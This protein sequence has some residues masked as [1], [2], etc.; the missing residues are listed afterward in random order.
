MN[1]PETCR[2]AA[3]V[4]PGGELE[5]VEVP[6]PSE[7][8]PGAIL[9]KVSAAT[10]CATDAHMW[11]HGEQG[12]PYPSPIIAGHEMMGR[13]ARIGE[14][15]D[16]DSIGQDLKVG[17]RIVWSSGQCG[18]C[19]PCV[20][21]H[22]RMLCENVRLYMM[23]PSAQYP[24]LTGGFA[25]YCYVFPT[26][27]RLKVPDGISDALASGTSCAYRTVINAFDRLGRIDEGQSILIQGSGP[28]GL[29]A[30][31]LASVSGAAKVIVIGGPPARLELAREFGADCTI[32]IAEV[33]DPAERE[34]IVRAQTDGHG[35]DVV[36][37]LSGVP[38]AFNEGMA[39]L[40]PAGRY[41]V[42]GQAHGTSVPFNPSMLMVKQATVIGTRSGAIDTFHR[43]MKFMERHADRFD[44]DKMITNTYAL[45]DINDAMAKMQTWEEIK[46]VIA[47]AD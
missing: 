27:S 28:L 9:V 34:K 23:S 14:G 22:E 12:D 16:K 41:I 46:P 47:F 31:A 6:V 32:D 29:F 21:Q 38:A 30:T 33:P 11:K 2:A 36:M 40:R 18:Q 17:D 45:E 8:E 4:R 1:I 3:Y 13:I 24:H 39:M 25:E 35:A 5:I 26:S 20:V 43:A 42:P 37:E 44:W 19:E 10:I 7:I 15:A